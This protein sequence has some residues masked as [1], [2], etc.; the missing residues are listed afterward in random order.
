MTHDKTKQRIIELGN[1][2]T[3]KE[4]A[5]FRHG[6]SETPLYSKWEGMRRRCNNPNDVSYPRYGAKGITVSDS[7]NSFENFMLDMQDGFAVGMS[8]DRIDSTKGYSKENC[9]WVPLAEQARNRSTVKKYTYQG[10][11]LTIPEWAQR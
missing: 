6:M 3:G 10:E 7:W 8:L 9:R 1:V 4:H 2:R 5:N 11:T